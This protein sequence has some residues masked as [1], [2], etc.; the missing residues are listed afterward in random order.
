MINAREKLRWASRRI[1]T[2]E[3]DIAYSLFGIFGVHLPIMYGEKR[4]NA[5]GR[6]LQEIVTVSGDIPA[7]DWIG[8]SSEFNSCLPA[9][10]TSYEAPSYTSPY[11][12]EDEMQKLVSSL[13][14]TGG[15]E[16]YFTYEVKADGV[17]DLQINSTVILTHPSLG[18][19]S[20]RTARTM[21]AIQGQ[22]LVDSELCERATRLIVQL[23]QPFS[24]F[25]F[26]AAT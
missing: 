1:T 5:L 17:H 7:L 18:S 4:Q 10:I 19:S 8:T 12:S 25:L 2:V 14:D 11:I 23:G 6:L 20:P 21:Q 3:E 9:D 24:A 26:S 22:G 13:Q 15:R 16:P